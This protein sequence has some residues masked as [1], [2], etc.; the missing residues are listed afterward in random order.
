[1]VARELRYPPLSHDLR[2]RL[3]DFYASDVDQLG[4]MLGR[5]LSGWLGGGRLATSLGGVHERT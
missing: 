4:H 1:M 3:V 5:D 2:A